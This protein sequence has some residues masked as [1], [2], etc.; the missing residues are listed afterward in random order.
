MAEAETTPGP[1]RSGR[2]IV[3]L[4]ILVVACGILVMQLGKGPPPPYAYYYDLA[5]GKTVVH[6]ADKPVPGEGTTLFRAGVYACGSC[7]ASADRKIL[8]VEQITTNVPGPDAQLSGSAT[9]AMKAA[10]AGRRVAPSPVTG[11]APA[12]V[13][14]NSHEGM[15]AREAYRTLCSGKP[16]QHCVPTAME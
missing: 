10:E 12:W 6:R 14:A 2:L 3:A 1:K 11:K 8:W 15:M 7:D 4:A 16:A 13:P 9:D 5:A